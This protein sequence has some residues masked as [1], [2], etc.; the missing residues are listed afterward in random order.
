MVNAMLSSP[1]LLLVFNFHAQADL[2][3]YTATTCTSTVTELRPF[4]CTI[5]AAEHSTTK[6]VDCLGCTLTTEMRVNTLFGH[7]PVCVDG[8]QTVTDA[9][10]TQTVTACATSSVPS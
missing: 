7:G 6:P 4:G 1:F 2:G 8:L 9:S 3:D 10:V 5:T